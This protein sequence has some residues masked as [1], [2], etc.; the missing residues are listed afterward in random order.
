M[1]CP[2]LECSRRLFSKKKIQKKIH[3]S[4]LPYLCHTCGCAVNL[5]HNRT[6]GAASLT[7]TDR[8][9]R[10]SSVGLAAGAQQVRPV[11]VSGRYHETGSV[12]LNPTEYRDLSFIN[13]DVIKNLRMSP[14]RQTKLR[15]LVKSLR[16]QPEETSEPVQ[17]TG[18]Q[19]INISHTNPDVSKDEGHHWP[20]L[21]TVFVQFP[22]LECEYTEFWLNVKISSC[23]E[24]GQVYFVVN[25]NHL[26]PW[27]KCELERESRKCRFGIHR[28]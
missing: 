23:R 2:T 17:E 19:V 16:A 10:P 5:P 11:N 15:Q 3:T 25:I 26:V 14:L 4:R 9:G 20:D 12:C 21:P 24:R 6:C 8:Q 22:V 18:N 13:D 27:F 7:Y 1:F 28:H